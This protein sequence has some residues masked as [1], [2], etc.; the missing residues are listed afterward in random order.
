MSGFYQEKTEKELL[1]DYLMNTVYAN[2]FP[3]RD[4]SNR[5]YL[6]TLSIDELEAKKLEWIYG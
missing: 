4:D 2:D 3:S 5:Q 6:D 1:I